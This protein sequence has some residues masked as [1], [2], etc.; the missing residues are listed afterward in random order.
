MR[1]G[2]NDQDSGKN[3]LPVVVMHEERMSLSTTGNQVSLQTS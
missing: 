1:L 3:L 2:R